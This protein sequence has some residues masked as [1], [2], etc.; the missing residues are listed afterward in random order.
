MPLGSSEATDHQALPS[1]LC[2]ERAAS[3]DE[4][5]AVS[6]WYCVSPR[7]ERPMDLMKEGPF[8]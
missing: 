5:A 2:G 3:G 8:L 4:L 1:R 7:A 6:F